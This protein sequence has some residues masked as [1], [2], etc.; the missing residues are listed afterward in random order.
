M[1]HRNQ[2]Q[3]VGNNRLYETAVVK[4]FYLFELILASYAAGNCKFPVSN[5]PEK[6]MGNYCFP[7]YA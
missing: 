6:I 5:Y 3:P 7:V 2:N 4:A 1:G